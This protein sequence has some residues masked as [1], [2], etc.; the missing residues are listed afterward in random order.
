MIETA[1]G[2]V[3]RLSAP[4]LEKDI[5]ITVTECSDKTVKFGIEAPKDV[6]IHRPKTSKQ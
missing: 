1:R 3:I 6:K 4:Q 5:L 2:S